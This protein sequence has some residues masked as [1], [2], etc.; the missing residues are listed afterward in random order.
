MNTKDVEHN[1]SVDVIRV[2]KVFVYLLMAADSAAATC[3][4]GLRQC[5]T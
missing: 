3:I 5:E 1:A 4:G 2:W